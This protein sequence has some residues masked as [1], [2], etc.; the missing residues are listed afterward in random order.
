MTDNTR[1]RSV[2]ARCSP[3]YYSARAKYPPQAKDRQGRTDSSRD[4][5]AHTTCTDTAATAK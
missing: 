1:S 2:R 3:Y 5:K 4:S